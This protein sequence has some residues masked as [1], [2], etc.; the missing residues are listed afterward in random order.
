MLA[1]EERE[2]VT[3]TVKPEEN[4]LYS[5]VGWSRRRMRS[6]RVVVEMRDAEVVET[7]IN[8]QYRST[9]GR[10]FLTSFESACQNNDLDNGLTILIA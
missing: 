7:G 3:V 1:D 9:S 4:G 6:L 2:T 10:A 5:S 8:N